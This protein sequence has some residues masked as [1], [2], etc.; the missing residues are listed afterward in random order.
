MTRQLLKAGGGAD[1]GTGA[2]KG[3]NC[4]SRC[5]F[6]AAPTGTEGEV[7]GAALKARSPRRVPGPV[8]VE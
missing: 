3:F 6:I 8:P 5:R 1:T 4:F 2:G 7:T